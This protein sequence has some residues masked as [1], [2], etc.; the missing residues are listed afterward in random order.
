MYKASHFLGWA[1]LRYTIL[2]KVAVCNDF[3]K[4]YIPGK[5]SGFVVPLNPEMMFLEAVPVRIHNLGIS[6]FALAVCSL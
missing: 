6:I 1:E 4:W 5:E 3:G 2:A